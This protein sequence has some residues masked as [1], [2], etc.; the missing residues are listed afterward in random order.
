MKDF[1]GLFLEAQKAMGQGDEESVLKPFYEH[2]VL[3]NER[4][5]RKNYIENESM[6]GG[7]AYEECILDF[8]PIADKEYL[9]VDKEAGELCG[10][11]AAAPFEED[12]RIK[13]TVS[14]ILIADIGDVREAM[15][16]V[17]QKRWEYIYFLPNRE[18]KRFASFFKIKE[19]RESLPANV[20][21]FVTTEEMRQYFMEDYDAY[22]PR[23]I[24]AAEP[25]RYKVLF[26][27]IH[28][29]RIQSGIPSNHV[30]LSV[31]IPTCN[32][33]KLALKAVKTALATEYDSEIEIF[34]CDNG[35][36]IEVDNYKE[37]ADMKDPRL[38][39]DRSPENK[40]Y[41][42][43]IMKGLNGA[44]GRFAIFFSD[45]DT[46]I[47]DNLSVALDWLINQP[48]YMGACIFNDAG[49]EFSYKKEVF[50][51]GTEALIR[52]FHMN[53]ITGC[54]FNL[55]NVK[56]VELF[57]GIEENNFFSSYTHCAIAGVL[58][59]RC[60]IV[61]TGITLWR[62]EEVRAERQEWP[63]KEKIPV[64][65][66]PEGRSQQAIDAI[67]LTAKYFSANDIKKAFWDRTNAYFGVL[68]E[69]YKP[70]YGYNEKFK[71]MYQ[72]LDI[73][74]M[75]YSHSL[76]LLREL[77]EKIGDV[78]PIVAEMNKSFF[79]WLICK[80]EQRLNT[81]EENLLPSLQA[82]VAKYYYEKGV[83]FEEI[84]FSKIEQDLSGWVQDFIAKEGG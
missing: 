35:S 42:Y 23:E 75:H 54:C 46:L 83:D 69:M 3:P 68:S 52:A 16:I 63:E 66:L 5:F 77:K 61:N 44:K 40:G 39:Y 36:T 11:F 13:K 70:E 31:C 79:Y 82:Q 64:S 65:Y 47:V 37:I 72:W 26:R 78:Q 74:V 67:R 48:S 33:G 18:A 15:S 24:V 50:E 19:F 9:V 28:E 8:I 55:Q 41:A 32:R 80:R 62:L 43:N 4:A 58:A 81:P 30:F 73:V 12:S 2:Y 51:P 6:L 29:A 49:G 76:Q 14:S 22:L 57:D 20:R 34:V 59:V 56:S 53:Y 7:I 21:F 84:D 45:E 27:E 1:S 25:E 71:K 38:R 10:T 17:R 60:C